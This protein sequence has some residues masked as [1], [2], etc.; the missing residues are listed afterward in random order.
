VGGG[1]RRAGAKAVPN[2]PS[3]Q[4]MRG[5]SAPSPGS[6]GRRTPERV[7]RGRA[8]GIAEVSRPAGPHVRSDAAGRNGSGASPEETEPRRGDGARCGEPPHRGSPSGTV[9]ACRGSGGD[10]AGNH[11]V[12]LRAEKGTGNRARCTE[13][14]RPGEASSLARTAAC[15]REPV[16]RE[17]RLE[18]KRRS[19]GR[20]HGDGCDD[21][22]GGGKTLRARRGAGR[23]ALLGR[24]S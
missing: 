17:V 21:R 11:E 1:G 14:R 8:M 2:R 7:G 5:D 3:R 13:M 6:R 10:A 24:P 20:R 22:P 19:P 12:R 4:T 9:A 16:Q 18:R 23:E 15:L